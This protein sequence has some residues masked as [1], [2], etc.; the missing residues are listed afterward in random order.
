M[1]CRQA[2]RTS[3]DVIY[4]LS[5]EEKIGALERITADSL[6][7]KTEEGT[8]AFAKSEVRGLDLPQPRQGEEWKALKD[9]DDP[10]LKEL[11][12]NLTLP[13]TDA[14][15]VNLYVEHN[16]ILHEDGRFEKR[17]R[18]IRYVSAESGKGAAANNTWSYLA[19]RAYARLDF[20]RS[21]SPEGAVSHI[22]EAAINRASR[23]PAPAE[24]SNLTEIQI[25][26]PES[27]VGSVLDFQFS[28]IQNVADSIHP[29][30]EEIVLA[31]RQPTMTEII[32]VEQPQGGPV[33]VYASSGEKPE[34]ETRK[35]REILTWTIQNQ[36]P[37]R[38]ELMIPP[39]EDYLPHF[40]VAEKKDWHSIAAALRAHL[41]KA[42]QPGERLA[43]LVDSLTQNL[44][45]SEEKARAMYEFVAVSI[46]SVGP[47]LDSYSC[48]PTPAETVLVRGF[49][50]NLDR[51]ALLYALMIQAGLE[52][53]LVLIRNRASGQLVPTFPTLGQLN[54]ALVLFE[55][56]IYLDPGPNVAFGTFSDQDAMGLSV[57]SGKLKKTPL[58]QPDQ[59][60]TVTR[61]EAQ[62]GTDG[63]LNLRMDVEF[64]GQNSAWWK[65][66]LKPL[67]PAELRQEAEELA[68][69]IH[70]NARLQDFSFNG[71]EPLDQEVSYTLKISIPGYATRAGDYLILYL[72]GV[73]H[74]A[75]QVGATDRT[76]PIDRVIRSADILNL[77]LQLPPG[78]ELIYY[79]EDVS[80]S[81]EYDSY[82]AVFV[83][84]R[85]GVLQFSENVQVLKPW[86]PPQ[87]YPKYKELVEGMA[88]LSQEP[89]VLKLR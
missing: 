64:N 63:S 38:F 33:E 39:P 22:T 66:Y 51:A 77:S 57:S 28:T 85:R 45:A 6:W 79:P 40:I 44:A 73:E 65:R 70:P 47:P 86:I 32:R 24:Y 61:T 67:S 53:D 83:Q 43:A 82:A 48:V 12:T 29:V 54:K 62:L 27:R 36:P 31:D 5:G 7:F 9:I 87:D 74:S 68:S 46:H 89:I 88:R 8:L 13:Q 16:F 52:A 42:I 84:P 18:V 56:R 15:Y 49:A 20:A 58:Y 17:M 69:Y 30:C 78:A 35:G 50:N 76:Y 72:P 80:I 81:N 19:D 11:F 1:G 75:Y 41:D 21:Y 60:A 34:R 4:L 59:E 25:A 10:L 2:V 37:M 55:D 3:H 26:V 71:I 23:Y 14:R